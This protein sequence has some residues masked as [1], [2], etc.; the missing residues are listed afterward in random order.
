[1]YWLLR[2]ILRG[3]RTWPFTAILF[4]TVYAAFAALFQLRFVPAIYEAIRWVTPVALAAFVIEN[5]IQ[6]PRIRIHLL[7]ML[8]FVLPVLGVYGILQFLHP[9]LWDVYWMNN[10]QNPTFGLPEAFRVRVFSMMNAP[11]PM[12]M[13]AA[14]GFVLMAASGW[15]TLLPALLVLPTLA[16]TLIRTAWLAWAAGMATLFVFGRP[17]QRLAIAL[18]L[19]LAAGCFGL[20]DAL[21]PTAQNL[22]DQRLNTFADMQT[23]KSADDRLEVYGRFSARLADHP[24]GEGFGANQG[25]ATESEHRDL[26]AIDSGILEAFLIFGI[27]C[28]CLYF[29]ALTGLS[30]QAFRAMHRDSSR[31]LVGGFAMVCMVAATLPLGLQQAGE[32][33]V[34]EWPALALLLASSWDVDNGI[35]RDRM[36]SKTGVR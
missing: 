2:L 31:K 22:L 27:P 7:A 14:L 12:G 10:I 13:F 1:M 25:T 17:R 32:L 19:A 8:A 4:C 28:G 11:M 21:P 6:A 33:G 16:L 23:D 9:P 30:I 26:E 24:L 35:C 15:V 5:R 20:K 3:R 36:G 29:A 18:V 34:L